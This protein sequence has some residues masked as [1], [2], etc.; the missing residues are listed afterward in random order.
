[1]KA[2][3]RLYETL[4]ATK[5][6]TAR[7]EAMRA[8]FASAPSRD[9]AWAVYVLSGRRQRRLVG[10]AE[11]RDWLQRACGYPAWLVEDSYAAVG[12]LAETIALLMAAPAAESPDAADAESAPACDTGTVSLADWLEHRLPSLRDADADA[13]QQTVV[14]WW[15]ALDPAQAFLVTKLLTGGLR[16]GVSRALVARA[17]AGLADVPQ[18]T[19]QHRLMGRWQPDADWFEGLLAPADDNAEPSRPYPFFLASPM[20][21]ESEP[22]ATLGERR[23][24]L[25]EW[26]WDGIRAQCIRRGGECFIWTR[27]EELVT[28]RYPEV[29]EALQTL[30]EGCVLDGELLAWRTQE[31]RALPFAALQRRI[32]RLK[33]GKRLREEVP[34]R[35]LAYDL[36]EFA[37]S[38]LREVPLHER[39]TQLAGLLDGAPTALGLSASLPGEDWQALARARAQSRELGVEGLMLKRM[40]SPYRAGRVRGDW[41]KWKLEPLTLDAVMIYAQAGHGRRASLYTDYTFAVWQDE[42]LVP[43]AKAY[44]GLSDAQIVRLD[45][46]I[47]KHTLERFGPV[48]QVEPLQVFELAFEGIAHSARHRSGVALRFPRIRR[49][50]EDLGPKDAD[51]LAQVQALLEGQGR[52]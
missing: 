40:D 27:G 7:V 13:R 17:L 51:S 50:R 46:W 16:V 31:D 6:T 37:G 1:M 35:L 32:G 30:P 22:A 45:R 34:V 4:D 8:Y 14:A 21:E 20:E 47:R 39:R 29:L 24:W 25:A 12:D 19:M 3:A 33:P 10:T 28:E 44:S 52:S 9:A 11:L 48:R 49:W 42:D 18:A 41:W 26:K 36:L 2:F 38:D 5:S 43:V 15:R 23:E